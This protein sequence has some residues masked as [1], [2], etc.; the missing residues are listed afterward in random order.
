[1][2]RSEE[3]A[4][5]SPEAAIWTGQ[6]IDGRMLPVPEVALA[7]RALVCPALARVRAEEYWIAPFGT[8][9]FE[10]LTDTAH[11]EVGDGNPVRRQRI[12]A[13]PCSRNRPLTAKAN[14]VRLAAFGIADDVERGLAAAMGDLLEVLISAHAG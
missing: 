11:A 6:R 3:L 9:G 12:D 13:H 14:A 7:L 10:R 5:G 1:L 8:L 4:G 2:V